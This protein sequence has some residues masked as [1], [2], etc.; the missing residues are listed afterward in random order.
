MDQQQKSNEARM[1][2]Y[3]LGIVAVVAVVTWKLVVR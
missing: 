3:L 1:Y 2:G